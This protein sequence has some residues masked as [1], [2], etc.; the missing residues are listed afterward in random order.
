MR[1]GG[2]GGGLYGDKNTTLERL[3][4]TIRD[5]LPKNVRDRLVLENDEVR[6]H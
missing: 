6:Q 1:L 5:V 4:G 2:Q 3:K